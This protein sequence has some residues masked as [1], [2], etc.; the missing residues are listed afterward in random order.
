MED[1]IIE[2]SLFCSQ[3]GINNTMFGDRYKAVSGSSFCGRTSFDVF[4][5]TFLAIQFLSIMLN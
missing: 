2:C 3:Q 4:G 5:C 1:L